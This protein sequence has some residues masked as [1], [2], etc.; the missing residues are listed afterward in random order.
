[1]RVLF[2]TSK[3]PAYDKGAKDIV[4]F[5]TKKKLAIVDAYTELDLAEYCLYV[6]T[7]DFIIIDANISLPE[8]GTF[9]KHI[10]EI[11][12]LDSNGTQV[13]FNKTN[14]TE[15]E[16]ARYIQTEYSCVNGEKE[17]KALISNKVAGTMAFGNMKVSVKDESVTISIL[18][19]EGSEEREEHTIILAPLEHRIMTY[20]F[21]HYSELISIDRLQSAVSEE[22]EFTTKTTIEGAIS[23]IKK[24]FK[25]INKI[26]S[27]I[28]NKKKVGYGLVSMA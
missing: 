13:I 17:L 24:K 19:A 28:V 5:L 18:A 4:N 12:K 10:G 1:M 21:R 27:P 7:Y 3:N 11:T 2:L 20:F 22:P 6:R 23:D 26:L 8:I 16:I 15:N 14:L 9:L 25:K